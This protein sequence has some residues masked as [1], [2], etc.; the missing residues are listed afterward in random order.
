MKVIEHLKAAGENTIF[1]F[2]ILPPLKGQNIQKIFDTI[3]SLIEF[4]PPFVNVTYHR[5]EVVYKRVGEGL[6]EQKVIKKR[7][8]T[9]GICAAIQNK[10]K[11]DAVPHILCGGFSKEDTENALIDLNFLGIENVLALRGDTIKGENFFVPEHDGH[12]YA[13]ELVQQI[14]DLNKGVYIDEELQ[15]NTPSDFCVGVAGYPEKHFEAPSLKHDIANL[16]LKIEAGA[17]YIVTQLFY[18]NQK[19]FDF[20]SKCREAG[21]DVPIVPGIK[22]IATKKHLSTIPHFFKVDMP[23]D[24][25]TA[26]VACKSNEEVRQVGIEWAIQQSKELKAFGVPAIHYYS[27]GKVDN[28]HAIASALF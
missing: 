20:V 28:I 11:I 3:D 7:P 13:S 4:K 27:M 26:V 18:D 8:G 6:L 19:F 10:Y 15:N 23:D 25:I 24:L 2:E 12:S 1:S 5:E 16:K 9:V 22:P 14:Y 17:E 21:I